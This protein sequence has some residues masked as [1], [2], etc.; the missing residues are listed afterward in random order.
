LTGRFQFTE[1]R[2]MTRLA[3]VQGL[4][5]VKPVSNGPRAVL[6]FGDNVVIRPE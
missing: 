3:I 6:S 4:L 1:P 5:G 2:I